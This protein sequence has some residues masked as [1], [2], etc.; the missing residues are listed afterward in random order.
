M[1]VLVVG[2]A[3]YVGGYLTDVLNSIGRYSVTVYDVLAYE[4]RFLKDVPFILGDIR[5]RKKLLEILPKFDIVIWLAAIVGDGACAADK[6]LTQSINEDSVKWLVSHY[7]GRIVFPSTCSVYGINNELIDENTAPNP[8]SIYAET[9]LAAESHILEKGS[10]ALIFRLGTLYGM[11]DEH[12][13]L[14]LDLVVNILAKRAACGEKLTVYGGDQWRPLIHVRDVAYAIEFGIAHDIR[15]LYN[16][17]SNNCRIWEIAEKI[18]EIHPKCTIEKV[19]IKYED[20]RNYR[21]KTEKWYKY[22]WLP[23]WTLT[24]GIEQI[25]DVVSEGRIKNLD[26]PI[27]SNEYYIKGKYRKLL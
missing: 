18:R 23:D 5:D 6:F 15:G 21:V 16:L 17:C 4:E 1:K 25:L 12:S 3:G 2:G 13:R 14:R 22:G 8:L 19:D 20:L 26:D 24:D 11:G 9:K 27:Y 10:D 7:D